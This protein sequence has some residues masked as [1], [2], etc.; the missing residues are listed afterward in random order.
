MPMAFK[1]FTSQGWEL[2]NKKEGDTELKP[3]YSTGALCTYKDSVITVN[4]VNMKDKNATYSEGYIHRV[5]F[6]LYS[7]S[8][9]FAE[10]L[11]TAPQF[12][13]CGDINNNSDIE[14]IIK[15]LGEPTQIN[16]FVISDTYS[17]IELQYQNSNAYDNLD[18][19]LNQDG[20]KIVSVDYSS[21]V[22]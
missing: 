13:V 8:D 4:C 9:K 6:D 22:K 21:D 16:Y 10:Q 17:K 1:D 12:T 7:S 3:G 14:D 15:S 19:V 11:K 5:L 2:K 18:F 20:S